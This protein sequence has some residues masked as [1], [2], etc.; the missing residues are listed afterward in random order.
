MIYL[1]QARYS[2]A[3]IKM[4]S[5]MLVNF[6]YV[7]NDIFITST[8]CIEKR[9]RKNCLDNPAHP[10]RNIANGQHLKNVL[11]EQITQG[12]PKSYRFLH[13][14]RNA[15]EIHNSSIQNY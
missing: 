1:K 11:V 9:Y 10:L 5:T 6:F 12:T 8:K 3:L 4:Q 7:G 13:Q 15:K 2:S 14:Q